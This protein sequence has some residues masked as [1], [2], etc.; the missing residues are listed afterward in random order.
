MTGV[1]GRFP[2]GGVV[3]GEPI[4]RVFLLLLLLAAP[5]FAQAEE[6]IGAPRPL[7]LAGARSGEGYFSA[8][9]RFMIFQSEREPGNPFYA[10]YLMDLETGS[11]RRVS[12]GIGKTTCAWVHPSGR[13]ALFASTHLDPEARKKQEEELA[14]RASGQQRRYSWD[15]DETYDLFEVDLDTGATTRL[16]DA[17]G[18]DAE[19]AW[20]PDGTKVVFASNRAAYEAGVDLGPDPSA[21]VDLYLLEGGK[22]RRL[23][24]HPGYDGG[25]FFSADGS[26]ICFRRFAPDGH[27]AEI[28]T[29][30]PDGTDVRPI[31]RL[32]AMSWAPFFHPSGDYLVF[33]TNKHGYANFELYLVDAAGDREPVRVTATD[34]FDGLPVFTP[35]GRG[36]AWTTNRG[37]KSQIW[38]AGWNDAE[39]RRLLGLP[40]AEGALPTRDSGSDF[41][42]EALKDTV[43]AL[44][45]EETEGR[46][47]GS[48]GARK[49]EDHVAA[50]FARLGLRPAGDGGTFF[51]DF[52]FVAGVSPG[53]N[54]RLALDG[55]AFALEKDWR[56]VA[57]SASGTV[58]ASE[59]AFAGYG[60]V[61]P[62]DPEYDSYVHL[63]VKDRWVVVLRYLPED[64]PAETRQHLS[65]YAGLRYKSMMA[66]ERG[67][68]GLI[69]ASGPRSQVKDPL[70]PLTVDAALAGSS[71]PVISVTDEVAEA[72]LG[73]PLGPLQEKLDRG[74]PVMGFVRTGALLEATV[75]VRQEKRKGRNVLARLPGRGLQGP[76][77]V[78]AHLDHLG[79]GE[80]GDSL[81]RGDEKGRIHYGA[82]DNAS[83]V[84]ALL[85]LAGEFS[86]RPTERDLLFAAWSGEE[87]GI[88]GSSHFV[89]TWKGDALAAY[90]N[91]DMVGRMDRK[92][93][94]QGLSS[95]PAWPA[96]LEWANAP[97]GLPVA[98]SEEA[99]LPT[100][101]TAFYLQKVPFL[102]FFTGAHSEYHTPRDRPETLN[103]QGLARITGLVA[104][105]VEG[106]ADSPLAPPYAAVEKPKEHGER[107]GLRAYLGT[108]PD[109][110]QTGV[111][112]VRL[113]GAAKGGPAE[114]AG[115]REG[116][117]VVELAGRKIENIYD[118]TYAIE[119]L[120]VGQTVTLVVRRGDRLVR[121][122]VTPE[123][124]Q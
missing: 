7:T 62:G 24:D 112:G 107:A 54:N 93:V 80:G 18:Y 81:A 50:E 67:A 56:P 98:L 19:A 34:G 61:A 12:P 119:A 101:S 33:A 40:V 122:Q 60:L 2:G 8:D 41:D 78:G 124:R 45:S 59:V 71:L 32:G 121:M 13:K 91:M 82:D 106:V 72:L 97:A 114:R 43:E 94:V 42:V 58:P 48:P 4:M 36:L 118:F 39:A 88:L 11:V 14:F 57:F 120:K 68:R 89:R 83:G 99:Y 16:T 9:G 76:V 15:Y 22:V 65:R 90:V 85:A 21:H 47:T 123:S 63:D 87:I 20:S 46:M 1:R 35:D 102:S 86:K 115:V 73:R 27:T 25:P 117:V 111:Q 52:E 113:A 110:S 108:I 109:Y 10:I 95:S 17:R 92:V 49:A 105:V 69:V 74:E 96:L 64:V 23:T 116:D 70:V 30:R 55:R 26:R 66:R 37:G 3:S 84:A 51:Q 100:D 75:D 77:V 104:R 79:R 103:Y 28:Y 29:M 31:T 5:A 6:L 44:A 38:L 53:P